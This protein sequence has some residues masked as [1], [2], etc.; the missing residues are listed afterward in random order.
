MTIDGI[1]GLRS[2]RG[3]PLLFLAGLGGRAKSWAPQ[4]AAIGRPRDPGAAM[5]EVFSRPEVVAQIQA[6]MRFVA[7]KPQ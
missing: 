5:R 3:A 1:H 2:G 6:A 7:P 4:F